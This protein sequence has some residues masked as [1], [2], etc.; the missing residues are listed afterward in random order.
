MNN[1]SLRQLSL[2][3][4]ALMFF[5]AL[6]FSYFT[7]NISRQVSQVERSWTSLQSQHNEKARLLSS[8]YN[9]LGYGGLVHHFKNFL[10]RKK[11]DDYI[12]VE[13]SLGSLQS[14]VKQYKALSSSPTEQSALDDIQLLINHYEGNLTIIR[15]EIDRGSSSADIDALVKVN[16][17]RAIRALTMLSTEIRTNHDFFNQQKNK[18]VLATAMRSE[19]GFGG[20]I[21]SFKN[22]ILRKDEKYRTQTLK[23]LANLELIIN[24]YLA[25]STS[26]GEETALQD[27]KA[28]LEQ[29]K[30][31]LEMIEQG[32]QS[33]LPPEKIDIQVTISDAYA[34]Q[35]L[36]TID[37]DII[38]QIENK[39]QQ[40]SQ[41][42]SN[43][44]QTERTNGSV[45]IIS[46]LILA[47]FLYWI[48][49]R[50]IINPVRNLSE[51]MLEMAN[52]NIDVP[53]DYLNQHRANE[54]TE[55]RK[56]EKSLA[57]FKQNEIKRRLAEE[58]IR[59]MA[60]TDPL[61]GLANLN[62]FKKRYH[63]MTLLANREQKTLALLSVDLDD[64]KPINDQ[65][66]H[67]AGDL[68]LKAVAKN[69][70]KT[71]RET[72]VVARLGGDEFSILLYSPKCTKNVISSVERL[73]ALIPAP[74][75]F[76]KD[77]LV[78]NVSVGIAF[79]VYGTDDDLDLLMHNSDKALYKAKAAGKNT[80]AVYEHDNN[81]KNEK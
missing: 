53:I 68:I 38:H 5:M 24:Q 42:I 56:M 22:Y 58:E 10:L 30:A 40:L 75:P 21:H 78:V 73:I 43:V 76:G 29:Y 8:F 41:M 72:D 2:I 51:I 16:D 12:Q 59:H 61:T 28:V 77:L 65:Y 26:I 11:F 19:L 35:G 36:K 31:S 79:H 4:F 34:L 74:V 60:L 55:L 57:V 44:R 67:A 63:E 66:G 13:Q 45:V 15:Q 52:G 20:M 48:F 49:S 46:V 9:H 27:I 80:Y 71:F 32:I 23:S 18:A 7:V 37:Q 1:L 6:V 81:E 47:L 64:F 39:S 50:K 33:M 69:M 70:L 14:I 25:L 17:A 3:I 62:Q 54:N